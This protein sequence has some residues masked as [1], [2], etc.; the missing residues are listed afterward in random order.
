MMNDFVMLRKPS[1]ERV[2]CVYEPPEYLRQQH[3]KGQLAFGLGERPA[4]T[5]YMYDGKTHELIAY[6]G[7][8]SGFGSN[9]KR[10]DMKSVKH[11]LSWQRLQWPGWSLFHLP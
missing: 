1:S 7:H 11:Y 2:L 5:I 8:Y 6:L 4:G 3:H 10:S 9:N